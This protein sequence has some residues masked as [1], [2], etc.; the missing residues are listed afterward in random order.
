MA[1][2]QFDPELMQHIKAIYGDADLNGRTLK[3]LH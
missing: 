3:Q 2:I 1:K